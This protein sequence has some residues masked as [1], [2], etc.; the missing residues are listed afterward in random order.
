MV[1]PAGSGG[2]VRVA[3]VCAVASALSRLSPSPSV[4]ATSIASQGRRAGDGRDEDGLAS[5]MVQSGA[6]EDPVA[7]C[8][9]P[10]EDAGQ[11]DSN[12]LATQP[13]KSVSHSVLLKICMFSEGKSKNRSI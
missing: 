11:D 7:G 9:D 5:G 12:P 10:L 6:D 3:R 13:I 8:P 2:T 1:L 4:T